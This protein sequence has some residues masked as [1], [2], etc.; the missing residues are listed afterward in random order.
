LLAFILFGFLS[1]NKIENYFLN[2]LAPRSL[3]YQYAL[4]FLRKRFP[5]GLGFS[6]FGGK[7]A[8]DFYSPIY[9]SLG[10]K[11]TYILGENSPFLLD[12]Y[13]PTIIGETGF[14]GIVLFICLVVRMIKLIWKPDNKEINFF[15]ILL[16]V[17]LV[18][19]AIPFNFINS[20][21]GTSFII[22]CLCFRN[23][24]TSKI[25]NSRFFI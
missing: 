9:E 7:I 6:F 14:I 11:N 25:R 3:L 12:A 22:I 19:S 5:F 24:K 8:S 21:I 13:F 10:W 17:C 2:S 23:L 16:F 4:L 20:G 15:S 1:K 18:L